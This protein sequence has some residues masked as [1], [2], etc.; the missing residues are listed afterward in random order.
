MGEIAR[1][2]V[3]IQLGAIAAEDARSN[4]NLPTVFDCEVHIEPVRALPLTNLSL[5]EGTRILPNIRACRV[6]QTRGYRESLP[7]ESGT[8][9]AC[10]DCR[11]GLRLGPRDGMCRHEQTARG[12]S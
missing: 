1:E 8:S 5:L 4:A 10:I 3:R 11:L 7:W 6:R 9:T 2:V 12:G